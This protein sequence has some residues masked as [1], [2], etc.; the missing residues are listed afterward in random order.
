[1]LACVG[2]TGQA[3]PLVIAP[4]TI[5][6]DQGRRSAAIQ[7][8]NA[9]DEPVDLQ[10]RAYDW[11]QPDGVDTLAPTR[12][13]IVSPAIVTVAPRAKQVFRVLQVGETGAG[14]RSYR[15]KLNELPR[16][17]DQAVG[18]TLEF[19]LPVFKTQGRATPVIR[20]SAGAQGVR[21]ANAGARRI[22]LARLAVRNPDGGAMELAEARSAYI[23]AG[24]ERRWAP[25]LGWRTLPGARLIGESD[26]GPI[27]VALPAP[28]A[29]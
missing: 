17:A 5:E 21:V 22:K 12:D 23:L 29:G 14:E 20:W 11:S 15:L 3:S 27:D 2:G 18:V 13:L 26:A 10:F 1:M 8:E 28:A 7:V 24:A 25:P 4:T 19:S 9:S 6:I 16:A